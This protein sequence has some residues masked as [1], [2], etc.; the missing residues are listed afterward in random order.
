LGLSAFSPMTQ[1]D[2]VKFVSDERTRWGDVIKRAN[3]HAGN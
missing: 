1:P 2:F 3:I